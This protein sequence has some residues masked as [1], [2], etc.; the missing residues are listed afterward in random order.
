MLSQTG[1]YAL[2]AMGYLANQET[3]EPILTQV[4]SEKTGIPK[5]FLSKILNRLVQGGLVQSVRGRGGG[6]VLAR[7]ANEIYLKDVVGLFMKMDDFKNCFLGVDTCNGK[8]G[9]HEKWH[10]I[11]VEFEKM[12]GETAVD[13]IGWRRPSKKK[14]QHVKKNRH[15]PQ[16]RRKENESSQPL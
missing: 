3:G 14:V 7:P 10:T 15:N 5:N 2:R 4:I 16:K 8:C 13:Q 11:V 6:F 1:I 12:I 9:L